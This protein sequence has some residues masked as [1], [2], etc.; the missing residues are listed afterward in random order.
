MWN[1]Q[2]DRQVPSAS[3]ATS[4]KGQRIISSE[5][6]N[7]SLHRRRHD[8]PMMVVVA[9]VNVGCCPGPLMSPRL[10]PLQV[11]IADSLERGTFLVPPR[12]RLSLSLSLCGCIRLSSRPRHPLVSISSAPRPLGRARSS[13]CITLCYLPTARHSARLRKRPLETSR[14]CNPRGNHQIVEAERERSKR[15]VVGCAPAPSARVRELSAR[16]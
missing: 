2:T 16:G 6:K 13:L 14:D 7:S 10:A 11:R 8:A 3:E 15:S 12:L 9:E 5:R 4:R 1:R